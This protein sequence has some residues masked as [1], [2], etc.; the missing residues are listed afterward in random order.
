M[1]RLRPKDTID[2]ILFDWNGVLVDDEQMHYEAFCGALL[3]AIGLEIT[4]EAYQ[5]HCQ[6]RRDR[7][8]LHSL[9]QAYGWNLAIDHCL[10]SKRRFY[11]EGVQTKTVAFLPGAKELLAW[12]EQRIPFAIVTS[13][14]RDE[15]EIHLQRSGQ[16]GHALITAEDVTRG[17]PDPEG[18]L[19]ATELLGLRPHR[20]LVI[21]DSPQNLHGL[22]GSGFQLL[23]LGNRNSEY[24]PS[25]YT[26]IS[27][28]DIITLLSE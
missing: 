13:S 22:I 18:Y 3:E 2:G 25:T 12:V 14:P 20:C 28:Y 23:G 4:L 24:P 27:L 8:G 7:D 15:V 19:L 16:T 5:K 11:H 17:K 1:N 21:E 26:A 10:I 9:A 6:G